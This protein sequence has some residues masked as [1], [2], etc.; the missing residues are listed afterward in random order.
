MELDRCH[1]GGNME[2]GGEKEEN[3]EQK[4]GN[5]DKGNIEVK[6]IK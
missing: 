2:R 5:A 1:L 3:V 6:R 4:G